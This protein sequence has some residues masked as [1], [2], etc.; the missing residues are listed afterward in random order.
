M[1][2]RLHQTLSKKLNAFCDHCTLHGAYYLKKGKGTVV[3]W[4][5]IIVAGFTLWG[6]LGHMIYQKYS[7]DPTV[8]VVESTYYGT[9][10]I[11]FPSFMICDPMP[12]YGPKAGNVSRIL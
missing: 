7:S 8:T 5:L 2:S 12:L 11:P 4:S 3:L 1:R 9:D 10:Q 6:V